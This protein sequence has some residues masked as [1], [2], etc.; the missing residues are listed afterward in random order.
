MFM[1][2]DSDKE[3]KGLRE[4][5]TRLEVQVE[6][7]TKRVDNLSNYAKELYNYLQKQR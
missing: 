7:L 4:R 2:D 6:E 1:P 3:A 5:V